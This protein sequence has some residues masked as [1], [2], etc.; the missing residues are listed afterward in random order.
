MF[1]TDHIIQKTIRINGIYIKKLYNQKDS[2]LK[3][4]IV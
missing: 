1:I 3:R 2:L 4:K